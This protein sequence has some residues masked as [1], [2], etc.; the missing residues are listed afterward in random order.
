MT[1]TAGDLLLDE[2]WVRITWDPSLNCLRSEWK[3]YATS[4]EY[5]AALLTA[6]R[7]LEST[8]LTTYLSDARKFKVLVHEDQ[9]W[10]ANVW[11]PRAVRAGL[12]RVAFVTAEAG[13]GKVTVEDV[14]AREKNQRV[15]MQAFQ[16]MGTAQAWIT[17]A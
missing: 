3:A 10:F 14:V 2:P 11:I 12:R 16:S 9:D 8:Q 13:L 15:D 5:R 7:T 17:A 6:L 4:A 1:A